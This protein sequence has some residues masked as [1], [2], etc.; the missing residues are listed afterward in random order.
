MLL[1]RAV[2]RALRPPLAVLALIV[3]VGACARRDE[4]TVPSN[5]PPVRVDGSSTVYLISKAVGEELSQQHGLM[6]NVNESGTTGGFRK[7]C[8]GDIDVTGAS[9]AIQ[10]AE[11]DECKRAGVQFVELPIGYDGLAV[12]VSSKNDWV[13]HLTVAEL[14]KMWSPEAKDTVTTWRQVRP[15]FPDRPLH[16]FGPGSDSGTF[17]YFTQAIVGTQR[18]SRID[19]AGSEDD[20]V[21]VRGVG[22]DENALGYF[23]YAYFIRNAA[24]LKLVPIDNGKGPV[25]PS[26]QTVVNGS[27]QPLSR[28]LFIYASLAALKR[29]EVDRFV[30]F[31]L[32][33]VRELSAE[34][35]YIALP[36]SVD[37]LAKQRYSARRTGSMF[38]GGVP[39]VGVTM[40]RLLEAEAR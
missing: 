16:L 20:T 26:K 19:Y 2:A 8:H 24:K 23:G 14:R 10:Q 28:P 5:A 17:D 33:V 36:M 13:D 27:Y 4:V 3:A 18:S 30:T 38:S 39:A 7:F 34:I 35:G 11:I 29:P 22:D 15:A 25:A 6:S 37:Q 9:R 32:Q 12:V 1:P 40:E 21:L 31:Y